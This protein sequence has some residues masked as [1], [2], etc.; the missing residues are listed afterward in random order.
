MEICSVFTSPPLYAVKH[1]RNLIGHV[2]EITFAG[3]AENRV[4]LLGGRG[5]SVSHID[6]DKKVASVEPTKEKG[7]SR[8]LGVG[9]YLSFTFCQA[10][11]HIL[12]E[13]GTSR[14]WSKRAVDK[15][16]DL[17]EEY[18]WNEVNRTTFLRR[19]NSL[20]WWTFAGKITN[21]HIAAIINTKL[22]KAAYADNL[23]IWTDVS[24]LIE[25][26][27][28]LSRI[29]PDG[30]NNEDIIPAFLK[31]ILHYKFHECLTLNAIQLIAQKR[32]HIIDHV[33]DVLRMPI[34]IVD[35]IGPDNSNQKKL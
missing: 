6:R 12:S 15:M 8:W 23:S 2:H 30:L 7:R 14:S 16:D 13:V 26:Q 4:I 9:P 28:T 20:R 35:D 32:F 27:R 25:A 24:A 33:K 11:K 19:K 21:L 10:I 34:N 5:W 29:G 18:K 17:R 22:G 3:S 1:G 31:T